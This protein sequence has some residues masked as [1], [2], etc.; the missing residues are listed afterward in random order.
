VKIQQRRRLSWPQGAANHRRTDSKQ[1]HCPQRFTT[2]R[3]T[4]LP[5]RLALAGSYPKMPEVRSNWLT[6]GGQVVHGGIHTPSL[7]AGK[8]AP[9]AVENCGDRLVAGP[10]ER[11]PRANGIDLRL[12]R[13]ACDEGGQLRLLGKEQHGV[14]TWM[15]NFAL[16]VEYRSTSPTGISSGWSVRSGLHPRSRHAQSRA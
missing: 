2:C 11:F 10:K 15:F 13:I 1:A 12:R 8:I 9:P 14:R 7:E 4:C 5:S 16:V 6:K 3:L